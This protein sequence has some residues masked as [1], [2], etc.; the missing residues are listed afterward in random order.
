MGWAPPAHRPAALPDTQGSSGAR[1][2]YRRA[3]DLGHPAASEG[4]GE[5]PAGPDTVKE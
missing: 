4:L 2:S 5:A 1:T 3:A